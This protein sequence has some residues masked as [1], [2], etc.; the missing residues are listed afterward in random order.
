MN[1]A[2]FRQKGSSQDEKGLILLDPEDFDKEEEE[3]TSLLLGEGGKV[4]ERE[5]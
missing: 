1:R 2:F 3:S 4:T 5:E